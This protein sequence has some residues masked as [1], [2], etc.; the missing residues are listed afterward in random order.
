M[1][2]RVPAF[3]RGPRRVTSRLAARGADT[4]SRLR[5]LVLIRDRSL[6][7]RWRHERVLVGVAFRLCDCETPVFARVKDPSTGS[8]FNNCPYFQEI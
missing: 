2:R 7:D 1:D 8:T 6:R 5:E 4:V 3:R